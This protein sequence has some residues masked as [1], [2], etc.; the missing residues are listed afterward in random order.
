MGKNSVASKTGGKPPK[1]TA[2]KMRNDGDSIALGQITSMVSDF[3]MEKEIKKPSTTATKI[4]PL[5][6]ANK[7]VRNNH[8]IKDNMSDLLMHQKKRLQSA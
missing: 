7:D 6:G 5:R 1:A 4:P 3:I 8:F 2:E